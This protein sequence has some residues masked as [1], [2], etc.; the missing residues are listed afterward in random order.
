MVGADIHGGGYLRRWVATEVG[1]Y[2]GADLHGGR[3]VG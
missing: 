3:L 1:S 2:V